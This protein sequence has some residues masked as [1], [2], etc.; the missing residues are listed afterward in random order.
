MN[1]QQ[2]LA[3]VRTI[4]GFD[5]TSES[6][7]ALKWAL[8]RETFRGGTVLLVRAIDPSLSDSEALAAARLNTDILLSDLRAAHSG[9]TVDAQFVVGDA[10]EQL[11]QYSG[12]SAVVAVGTH[13]REGSTGRFAWSVGVRLAARSHGPVAIIPVTDSLP[14]GPIVVG[15]DGSASAS[16]ALRFAAEEATLS[17]RELHL[18]HAWLEPMAW[19]DVYAAADENVT[20][21]VR[22]A[23]ENI[24]AEAV[25]QIS[26]AY[27]D[28]HVEGSLVQGDPVPALLGASEQASMV[29]V[30]SRGLHGFKRFLLGSVSHTTAL[31]VQAPL[32][33]VPQDAATDPVT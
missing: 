25:T 9:V 17:E 4:V 23:H 32:V 30:G 29:V 6:R 33:V 19:Q 14:D 5:D 21:M 18:L 27:P 20:R 31:N 16:A 26:E 15:V 7:G 22:E 11:E 12:P 10:C 3:T 8:E 28:L 24:L 1:D 2:N 13:A